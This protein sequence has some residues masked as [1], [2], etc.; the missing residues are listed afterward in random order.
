[1]VIPTLCSLP[2]YPPKGGRRIPRTKTILRLLQNIEL[3]FKDPELGRQ[4]VITLI[5]IE[6]LTI[7]KFNRTVKFNK[8]LQ[9]STVR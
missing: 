9:L 2:S 4:I 3:R 5:E 7:S 8:H 1:M 6:T